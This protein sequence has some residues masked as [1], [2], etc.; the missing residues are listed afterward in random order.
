MDEIAAAHREVQDGSQRTVDFLVEIDAHILGAEEAVI[1][2]G[3]Q[4]VAQVAKKA[5]VLLHQRR[6]A[7]RD[8]ADRL[9]PDHDK[10][11]GLRE[12]Y[13]GMQQVSAGKGV[14]ER[15][16]GSRQRLQVEFAPLFHVGD[17][18]VGAV[19]ELVGGAGVCRPAGQAG[20]VAGSEDAFALQAAQRQREAGLGGVGRRRRRCRQGVGR[21]CRG[22]L[23]GQ[24]GG[25]AAAGEQ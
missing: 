9:Q 5:A 3:L 15:A 14:K 24:G 17:L 6:C 2:D 22:R 4:G 8:I 19:P 25:L 18:F 7:G 11:V 23:V 13:V 20:Q 16:P 21:R 10:G 1:Q 12:K